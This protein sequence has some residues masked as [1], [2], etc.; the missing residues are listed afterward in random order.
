MSL[1]GRRFLIVAANLIMEASDD[2]DLV[3]FGGMVL[4]CVVEVQPWISVEVNLVRLGEYFGIVRCFTLYVDRHMS[5]RPH[6]GKLCQ[7]YG[8][9]F[10]ERC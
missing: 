6:N 7:N 5:A 10:E 3:V 2:R 4:V 1:P 8:K 9:R